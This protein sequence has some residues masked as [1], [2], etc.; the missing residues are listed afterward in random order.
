MKIGIILA[1]LYL[2]YFIWDAYISYIRKRKLEK[3]LQS[4]EKNEPKIEIKKEIKKDKETTDSRK[5]WY[6]EYLKTDHWQCMRKTALKRA[7]YKCQ[8]CGRRDITLNVHH[9]TYKNIGHEYL[10][11]LCV[12][13]KECHE[14]FHKKHNN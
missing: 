1:I 6:K 11:D 2:G 3:E 13:C 10:T 14:T 5:E 12:L 7:D 4:Y 9:N 8:V